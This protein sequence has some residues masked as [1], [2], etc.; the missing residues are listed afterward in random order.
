MP[1][2]TTPI[3][4]TQGQG[5]MLQHVLE[6]KGRE[7]PLL[8]ISESFD[9]RTAENQAKAFAEQ[10]AG[11]AIVIYEDVSQGQWNVRNELV[12]ALREASNL[13]PFRGYSRLFWPE[14]RLT[15][16]SEHHRHPLIEAI[17]PGP[18]INAY[19]ENLRQSDPPSLH[20][21]SSPWVHRD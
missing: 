11:Q 19:V 12:P 8:F 4:I 5:A 2:V 21:D 16:L 17:E 7:L 18:A 13:I 3:K 15:D 6:D 1:V 9:S 20:A 14:V 10:L